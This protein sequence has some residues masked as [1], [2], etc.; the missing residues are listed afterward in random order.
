MPSPRW[1]AILTVPMMACAALVTGAPIAAADPL[2][3]TY[4]AQL[5]A[6]G[7]SWPPNHDDALTAMGRFICDDLAWGW[8]Y[9][10]IAQNVHA[11]LD[12]RNVKFGEV[13]S[14]VSLAH[15]T[16]CPTQPCWG[17]TC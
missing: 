12:P 13:R 17:G 11:T 7:F 1:L 16:Y 9:D 6:A 3:D 4:L 10:L 5:R 14:M 15:S 8:N 2:D